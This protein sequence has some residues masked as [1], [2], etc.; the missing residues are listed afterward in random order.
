MR[1]PSGGRTQ[2]V[3]FNVTSLVDIVFLLIIFFLVA[4]HVAR[5][6]AVEPV[7]LPLASKLDLDSEAPNRIV[8]TVLA[9]RTMHMAGRQIEISDL[10]SAILAASQDKSKPLEVWMRA[11]RTATYAE[12]EPVLLACAKFGVTKVGFHALPKRGR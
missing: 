6:D 1:T 3:S 5:S 9:D 7:D 11:D 10:E 12:V 8:L 2:S 4:S